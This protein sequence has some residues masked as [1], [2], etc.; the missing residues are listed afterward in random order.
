[1]TAQ[2]FLCYARTDKEA[3]EN[4]YTG[5]TRSGFKPW[6]DTKDILP[7]EN[8]KNSIETAVDRSDFFI[9]CLSSN[10]VDRRGQIQRELKNALDKWKEKL[11]SDIYLIPIKL[12]KCEVPETLREFQWVNLFEKDGYAQLVKAVREGVNRQKKPDKNPTP[13]L[14]KVLIVEDEKKWQKILTRIIEDEAGQVMIA[15]GYDEAIRYLDQSGFDLITLDANLIKEEPKLREGGLVLHWMQEKG[16]ETPTIIVS[17]TGDVQF[18]RTAFKN[19]HIL[20][21]I[22]KS[23]FDEHVEIFIRAV[24]TAREKAYERQSMQ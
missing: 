23:S 10:S 6:M 24:R 4:L 17:G 8:W 3:V 1:M 16:L 15:E 5:L 2:I 14:F 22:E 20:D 19:Y 7:G 21:F 18:T 13:L 11:D 12:E 9:A